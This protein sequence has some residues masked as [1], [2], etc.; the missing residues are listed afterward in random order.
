M[1]HVKGHEQV[2]LCDI[3]DV[4]TGKQQKFIAM[5]ALNPSKQRK[6]S[7]EFVGRH[8]MNT[9]EPVLIGGDFNALLSSTDKFQGNH[10][11]SVDVEDF[12]HC[13]QVTEMQEARL[14]VQHIPGQIIRME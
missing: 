2:V 13:L 10:V 6:R 1:Q 8:C 9:Q 12:Q 4:Q 11:T 5:Y 14:L 7:W 3:M